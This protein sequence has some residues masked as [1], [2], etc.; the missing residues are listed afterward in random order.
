M[1]AEAFSACHKMITCGG[2]NCVC[3]FH[4][5]YLFI[6]YFAVQHLLDLLTR[7]WDVTL[8]PWSH[9]LAHLVS[10]DPL[11]PGCLGPRPGHRHGNH[12]RFGPRW[13]V[14]LTWH[15]V[16]MMTIRIVLWG[17]LCGGDPRNEGGDASETRGWLEHVVKVRSSSA[18]EDEFWDVLPSR[19]YEL[20]RELRQSQQMLFYVLFTFLRVS[21]IALP[22]APP[23]MRSHYSDLV[24]RAP[25]TRGITNAQ[26][27]RSQMTS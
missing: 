17:G 21:Q 16:G 12:G 6:I 22:Y 11:H 14:P 1:F 20:L 27:G 25:T 19:N 10:Q 18:L 9:H 15:Q 23:V 26:C 5:V 7:L 8:T 3:W 24:P 2:H 13:R 4:F